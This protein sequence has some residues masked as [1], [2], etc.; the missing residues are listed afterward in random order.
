MSTALTTLSAKL[1]QRF[2]IGDGALDVLK[3]TAFK[4]PAQ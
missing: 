3:A 1:A 4:G 2:G